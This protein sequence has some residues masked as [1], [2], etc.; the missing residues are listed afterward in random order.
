MKRVYFEIEG[1]LASPLLS[2]SGADH[3]T[4]MDIV[5]DYY[6]NP[7]LP[8]TACA[9]AFRQWLMENA[10]ENASSIASLFGSQKE[11]PNDLKQSRLFI[12]DVMFY[13]GKAIVRDH[14]HLEDK[15]AKKM[16]KFDVE[17]VE[18]GTPFIMRLE[19]IERENTGSHSDEALIHSIIHGLFSGALKLGG[20]TSRGYGKL[21]VNS[22][23]RKVFDYAGDK[24]AVKEWLDWTFTK[25]D[26]ET[27]PISAYKQCQTA[28]ET[29]TI[30]LKIK[31]TI[32]V[33]DY[34]V[35]GSL[36]YTYLT[37]NGSPV[38]PGTTWAGAFR[39]QLQEILNAL[40]I[41]ANKSQ[42]FIDQLF[43]SK[44]E[45]D[46][47]SPSILQ[48]EESAIRE[49][50]SLVR[51]RNA[52]DRFSGATIKG[53]LFTGKSVCKGETELIIR[54]NR[55]RAIS[56]EIIRGVLYWLIQDLH[57]GFLAIG[58]ETAVG[59]G[60]FELRDQNLLDEYKTDC[61]K[62]VRFL[63]KEDGKV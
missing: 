43:G 63:K 6:G 61:K 40:Q 20:K 52:I 2:G 44:K 17:L 14:V 1:A 32:L 34:K 56:N 10:L 23:R 48:F 49:H 41:D 4:N 27:V 42:E 50:T 39:H 11:D 9:G 55:K 35:A 12:S 7:F 46:E 19:Y 28:F 54:W 59:R 26:M 13:G 15:V 29:V 58:G 24:G 21:T 57:H 25:G 33:R 45:A 16:G 8:G 53:A 60:V 51:T 62:V 37:A 38:I 47:G 5:R 36:D 30:P 22:V 31:Q 3:F 18:N